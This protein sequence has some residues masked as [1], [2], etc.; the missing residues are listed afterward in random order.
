MTTWTELNNQLTMLLDNDTGTSDAG[1]TYS[2]A[3]RMMA[4][5][6]A[7]QLFAMS[8]TALL[9]TVTCSPS[10]SGEGL[11]IP[12]PDDW[13][14]MAGVRIV[15]ESYPEIITFPLLPDLRGAT[16]GIWLRPIRM[17]PGQ[18]EDH[19][20]YLL[21][22]EDIYLPDATVKKVVIWYWAFYP[23]IIDPTTIIVDPV[24]PATINLIKAPKRAEWALLNL[25]MSY[26]LI[27]PAIGVA[28]LRRFATRRDSGSPEDNPSRVQS[29]H[30]MKIY[31]DLVK[32]I[33]TVPRQMFYDSDR[34]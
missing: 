24:D 16:K 22:G 19:T 30:H 6:R 33:P 26:L 8:H 1:P 31:N 18:Y 23:E 17:V 11:K 4:W 7:C 32:M 9:K 2:A 5:N 15:D 25:T 27:A 10:T 3:L 12:F 28:D 20:G 29:N 34:N 13:I 21:T 14:D